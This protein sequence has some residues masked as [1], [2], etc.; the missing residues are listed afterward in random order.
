MAEEQRAYKTDIVEVLAS[1]MSPTGPATMIADMDYTASLLCDPE[2]MNASRV[3][4]ILTLIEQRE[5][6]EPIVA[7][8]STPDG[9]K[10]Y[11]NPAEDDV[12]AVE[13]QKY[14]TAKRAIELIYGESL[15]DTYSEIEGKVNAYLAFVQTMNGFSDCLAIEPEKDEEIGEI[16]NGDI[17]GVVTSLDDYRAQQ[18][19]SL[20]EHG[21]LPQTS[22]S[23]LSRLDQ[24]NTANQQIGNWLIEVRSSVAKIHNYGVEVRKAGVDPNSSEY[25]EHLDQL[26]TTLPLVVAMLGRYKESLET[27]LPSV[28]IE[29]GK[30]LN[31][32]KKIVQGAKNSFAYAEKNVIPIAKQAPQVA[33]V[34]QAPQVS[35]DTTPDYL[36][37]KINS[38]NS[39]LGEYFT[40]RGV[41]SGSTDAYAIDVGALRTTIDD[42]FEHKDEL[43]DTKLAEVRTTIGHFLKEYVADRVERITKSAPKKH[44]GIQMA[45]Q[46]RVDGDTVKLAKV[47]RQIEENKAY[48]HILAEELDDILS[49]SGVKAYVVDNKDSYRENGTVFDDF[50]VKRTIA[51][52]NGTLRVDTALL[53]ELRGAALDALYNYEV[54]LNDQLNLP[55]IKHEP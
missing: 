26:K 9:V 16:G 2:G 5:G 39:L 24:Q 35:Q 17:D 50:H 40:G 41:A 18:D 46:L 3:D 55:A 10:R 20:A 14:Q 51:E 29:T 43:G 4:S 22:R 21:Y 25:T 12:K 54:A 31:V 38:L 34:K 33:I 15:P 23:V 27:F 45:E 42:I 11:A 28:N 32:L 19:G 47:E 44:K 36:T 6:V 53:T 13:E 8:L 30:Y 7:E 1:Y 52:S 48:V 37:E 49:L